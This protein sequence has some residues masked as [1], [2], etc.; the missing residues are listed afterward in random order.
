MNITELANRI[1]ISDRERAKRIRLTPTHGS[2]VIPE[3]V[4]IDDDKYIVIKLLAFSTPHDRKLATTYHPVVYAHAGWRQPEG[5]DSPVETIIA[6][7]EVGAGSSSSGGQVFFGGATL[8]GPAVFDGS[9]QFGVSLVDKRSNKTLRETIDLIARAGEVLG[10]G[11]ELSGKMAVLAGSGEMV[12]AIA[13]QFLPDGQTEPRV[14]ITAEL[15]RHGASI[16]TGCFALVRADDDEGSNTDADIRY[17]EDQNLLERTDGTP[18]DE[19][20]LVYSINVQKMNPDRSRVPEIV[21][22][23]NAWREA[24]TGPKQ[25]DET[26]IENAFNRYLSEISHSRSLNGSDKGALSRQAKAQFEDYTRRVFGP[27]GSLLEAGAPISKSFSVAFEADTVADATAKQAFGEIDRAL[28][29][30]KEAPGQADPAS[31]MLDA[32]DE[33]DAALDRLVE[34]AFRDQEAAQ[35]EVEKAIKKLKGMRQWKRVERF[36]KSLRDRGIEYPLTAYLG[37]FAQLELGEVDRAEA[38]ASR[39]TLIARE[40]D[41]DFQRSEILALK[42]RIWKSRAIALADH[43]SEDAK[44]AFERALLFYGQA[45]LA[46][47]DDYHRVNILAIVAAARVRGIKVEDNFPTQEWATAMIET[48]ADPGS[49]AP[50]KPWVLANAGEASLFLDR[51]DQA[52][53]YYSRF[54]DARFDKPF[55]MNSSRRQLIEVW[56]IQP[57]RG[58]QLSTLVQQMG[59]YSIAGSGSLTLS[60]KEIRALASMSEEEVAGLAAQGRSDKTRGQLEAL[61]ESE[62]ALSVSQIRT[63]LRLAESVGLIRYKNGDPLGTGFL[64]EGGVLHEDWAGEYVLVTNEHVVSASGDLPAAHP[65]EVE[66]VLHE[67]ESDPVYT[68]AEELWVSSRDEHDCAV[69]RLSSNPTPPSQPIRIARGLPPR[70]RGEVEAERRGDDRKPPRVLVIGHPMG[71]ELSI[72]FEDNYLIDHEYLVPASPI[73]STPVRVHYRAPTERGNSGSPV[74]NLRTFELIALHHAG[75]AGPLNQGGPIRNYEAN[76]GLWIQAIRQAISVSLGGGSAAPDSAVVNSPAPAEVEAASGLEVAPAFEAWDADLDNAEGRDDEAGTHGAGTMFEAAGGLA[77]ARDEWKN[78]KHKPP[79]GWAP[80]K[81]HPDTRHLADMLPELR[82]REPFHLNEAVLQRALELSH[83]RAGHNWGRRVLFGIRGAVPDRRDEEQTLA[84]LTLTET[85][86]NHIDYLC[87]MGVWDRETGS[88]WTTRAS[89]VPAVGYMYQQAEVGQRQ[90]VCNMMPPGRYRYTVGTHA[91]GSGTRQ[92]GAFRQ[93]SKICTMRSYYLDLR[94]D[95]DDVWDVATD[96]EG[97]RIWDNIHA[98][99]IP[100]ADWG[101]KHYS[102]GCQV[103]PG[104]MRDNRT[105]PIGA[106]AGFRVAAG[107]ADQPDIHVIEGPGNPRS[108]SRIVG[109]SEDGLDFTYVLL[110]AREVHIASATLHEGSRDDSQLSRLRRGSEGELVRALQSALGVGTDGD[111]GF[112]TQ[113]ALIE[114]QLGRDNQADGVVTGATAPGLGFTWPGGVELV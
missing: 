8:F 94:F 35:D 71:R 39:A 100:H 45:N 66:V 44:P 40:N 25:G 59:L 76:Q 36:E 56:G 73:P 113:R 92:P 30:I 20:Y 22:A 111:F 103:L 61:F 26:F 91:N 32:S 72:T 79:G 110:T 82:T 77:R 101:A 12:R 34:A 58:D 87:T 43:K 33:I 96:A 81:E 114:F 13:S 2:P 27:R 99:L 62:R 95:L 106:W 50:D 107:L 14:G 78:L 29:D 104:T 6:P 57:D 102:A 4:S 38:L 31:A 24:A 75:A 28:D 69:L 10:V 18:L 97:I 108:N 54:I 93:A 11:L 41:D 68:V 80:I 98:G 83:M 5:H 84:E 109:T 47:D 64:L 63:S 21:A 49:N 51:P 1:L 15:P 17:N 85:L 55:E 60:M 90:N 65:D 16:K 86:P 112:Q 9:I 105:R 7:S 74:F 46:D 19:S 53:T 42:G 88:L 37:A 52:A 70:W 89:T 48:V 67:V 3:E 23:K